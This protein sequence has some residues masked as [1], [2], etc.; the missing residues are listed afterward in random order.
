MFKKALILVILLVLLTNVFSVRLID[1]VSKELSQDDSVGAFAPGTKMELIFSKELG[2]FDTMK[3]L[4]VLPGGFAPEIKNELESIKLFISLPKNAAIGDYPLAIEFSGKGSSE[5]IRLNFTVSNDLL[6]VSM[7]SAFE[8]KGSVDSAL[9]YNFQFVN[10]S[11]A[12]V[13]FSV[14]PELPDY[15]LVK[16]SRAAPQKP[17]ALEVTVPKRST[18]IAALAVYPRVPGTKEFDSTV[19][20]G[21]KE[22]KFSLSAVATP[23]LKSKL[24]AVFY[25]L[26]FY[27]FSL[28]PSYFLSGFLALLF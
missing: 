27:S 21:N 25:G 12:D 23:T 9:L 17:F 8:Q 2:R 19:T 15:W 26:P 13:V 22:Q 10:D 4:T 16:D 28:L 14:L 3:L 11:Y 18:K 7:N 24:D 6:L 20:F 1:P 5:R